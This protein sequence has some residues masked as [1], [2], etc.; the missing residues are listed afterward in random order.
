MSKN[1]FT[2]ADILLPDL[3][4]NS[5]DWEKWSVIACDQ[6][7]SQKEYWAEVHRIASGAMSAYSLILPEAY[8]ETGREAIQKELIAES[9]QSIPEK[10]RCHENSMIYVERTLPDGKLRRGIVGAI[11]LEKYDYRFENMPLVSATEETV[12]ERIPPRVEIR[13]EATVELPHVMV[14]FDDIKDR[15]MNYLEKAKPALEKLYDFTLMAGGGSVVGYKVS[16]KALDELSVI[17]GEYEDS[18]NGAA[19]AVGDGNH[20]LAGAKTY[21]EELKAQLGEA[22]CEHPARYALCEIVNIHEKS[23]EFEPIYRIVKNVDVEDMIAALPESERRT[24]VYVRGESAEVS[25]PD[26][27]PIDIGCLQI[28]I[29]KYIEEHPEAVCDYIHGVDAVV[30]LSKEPNSVGFICSGIEK[31]ALLSYVAEN[32]SLPRK[33]F[34]MGEAKSKR[35]YLEARKI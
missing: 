11:D 23:I 17:M 19:Y 30:E 13:R 22:A 35:Y 14:F 1:I 29:D 5:P 26:I 20:S 21:Y 6:F 12:L 3:E 16:G 10:L 9:M 27:H 15:I 24:T 31:D 4:L 7:T 28:F 2:S 34:S 25:L 18:K 33:T 8:L 32:G